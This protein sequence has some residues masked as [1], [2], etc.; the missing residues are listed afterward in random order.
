MEGL[1]SWSHSQKYKRLQEIILFYFAICQ[2]FAE[3][4][5]PLEYNM[6]T[7]TIGLL[8]MPLEQIFLTALKA[9]FYYFIWVSS[10]PNL[11]AA[12]YQVLLYAHGVCCGPFNGVRQ[13]R[14]ERKRRSRLNTRAHAHTRIQRVRKGRKEII[15]WS[16]CFNYSLTGE[17]GGLW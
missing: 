7:S 1:N 17:R 6:I 12:V 4:K 11:W 14:R 10:F 15:N 3:E 2:I 13:E 5:N 8:F 9:H 16:C